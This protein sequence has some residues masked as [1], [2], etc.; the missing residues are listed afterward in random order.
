[1]AATREVRTIS[2]AIDCDPRAVH[3]FASR[4]ETMPRWASG[5]GASLARVNGEWVAPT[6]RGP[7]RFAERN[8][9]GVLDHWV[10]PGPGVEIDIPMRVIA[11]AKGSA[12]TVTLFRLPEMTDETFAADAAWVARATSRRSRTCSKPRGRR[13]VVL[14]SAVTSVKGRDVDSGASLVVPGVGRRSNAGGTGRRTTRFVR[15]TA[16]AASAGGALPTART[17]SCRPRRAKRRRP[18]PAGDA[19]T[20]DDCAAHARRCGR[21]AAAERA[22][23]LAAAHLAR[24]FTRRDAACRRTAPWR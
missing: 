15:R 23:G 22:H 14:G 13:P 3:D 21:A 12:L 10:S 2:V 16:L 1:L 6:P 8:G 5:L 17:S 24:R 11:N 19:R 18:H 4:P 20:L 7:V 9:F